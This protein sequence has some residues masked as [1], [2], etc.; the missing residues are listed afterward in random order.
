MP[1]NMMLEPYSTG[2]S[3]RSIFTEPKNTYEVRS[4]LAIRTGGQSA[5]DRL[6]KQRNDI[7]HQVSARP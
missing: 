1:A 2:V 6:D 5:A 7:L 3:I 4:T